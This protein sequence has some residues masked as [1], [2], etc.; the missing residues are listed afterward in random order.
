MFAVSM[1]KGAARGGGK[2]REVCVQEGQGGGWGWKGVRLQ[3]DA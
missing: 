2:G 3:F 1:T